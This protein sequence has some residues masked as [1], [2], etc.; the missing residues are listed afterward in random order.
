MA[1]RLCWSMNFHY[2]KPLA[3]DL[4]TPACRRQWCARGRW[5]WAGWTGR[6]CPRAPAWTAGPW[7]RWWTGPPPPGSAPP[8]LFFLTFFNSTNLLI[9]HRKTNFLPALVYIV[10]TG[11]LFFKACPPL[12]I[13]YSRRG[14]IFM[15]AH[16]W[17]L[18]RWHRI[19]MHAHHWILG[20]WQRIFMHAHHRILGRWQWDLSVTTTG[21]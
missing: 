12:D 6:P 15:R 19:Y 20:R 1:S 4:C 21:Y 8:C 3:W 13:R 16:H 14:G 2:W 11:M 5:G 7:G 9:C 17:I 18:G 10:I